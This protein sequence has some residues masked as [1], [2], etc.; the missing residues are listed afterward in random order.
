MMSNLTNKTEVYDTIQNLSKKLS[1]YISDYENQLDTE[2]RRVIRHVNE[3]IS[4]NNN[5]YAKISEFGF[6]RIEFI[7]KLLDEDSRLD[8]QFKI[9]LELAILSYDRCI[10]TGI[11]SINP[12]DFEIIL[13]A[14]NNTMNHTDDGYYYQYT[15]YSLPYQTTNHRISTFEE[16]YEASLKHIE[17]KRVILEQSCDEKLKE[18]EA[19]TSNF[20]KILD[21]TAKELSNS[22][23]NFISSKKREMSISLIICGLLG[24]L[25]LTVTYLSIK[26]PYFFFELLG[27]YSNGKVIPHSTIAL[28]I[29][30]IILFYFF[31]ISLNNYYAARDELLQL[32]IRETLCKF[33]LSYSEF[34]KEKQGLEEFAKHIFSP[35]LSS[36]NKTPHPVDFFGQIFSTAKKVRENK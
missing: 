25:A 10:S 30:D 27:S 19:S 22:F 15:F 18:I 13:Y 16:K 36:T 23:S 31:R 21:Q 3:S 7:E 9:A 29:I 6:R 11:I 4:Y 32:Q 20:K 14:L 12:S 5:D 28:I 26:Q 24:C 17:A 2:S 33:A 34:S 35:M 8:N 1:N